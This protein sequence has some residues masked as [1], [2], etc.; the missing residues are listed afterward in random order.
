MA[1]TIWNNSDKSSNVTLSGS[2]LVVCT[3]TGTG[4]LGGVRAVDRQITGKFFWEGVFTTAP[5]INTCIGLGTIAGPNN[6]PPIQ[7]A[8]SSGPWTLGIASGV[9]GSVYRQGAFVINNVGAFTGAGTRIGIA[10][11][12]TL[13]T[14]QAWFRV[15]A[16]NW[17]GNAAYAPSGAGGIPLW[18]PGIPIYPMVW[19]GGQ[20]DVITANFGDAAFGGAVPSGYT[21]GFTAGATPSLNDVLTQLG[22]EVWATGGASAAIAAQLT[23]MGI[24]VWATPTGGGTQYVLTKVA[25]E[26][27]ASV[28]S[29]GGGSAG[30]ARSIIMA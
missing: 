17:N 27:W 14:P 19:T 20:N 12:L 18:G 9:S 11:D 22:A 13:T 26:V 6:V 23:Q 28:A 1:N 2:P 16:G 5:G 30:Q 29:S 21:S 3:Q 4:L 10:V 8:V 15:N 25:A 7:S 24:E